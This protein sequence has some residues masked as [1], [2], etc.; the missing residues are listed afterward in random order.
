VPAT[1]VTQ[2]FAE[3]F[4]LLVAVRAHVHFH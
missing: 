3:V 4:A 2:V 1:H